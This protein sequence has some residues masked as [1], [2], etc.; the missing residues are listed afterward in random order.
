[1]R[2]HVS[3]FHT[4]TMCTV[5]LCTHVPHLIS[6]GYAKTSSRGS[7]AGVDSD[8]GTQAGEYGDDGEKNN[9]QDGG[10]DDNGRDKAGSGDGGKGGGGNESGR[11]GGH[12]GAGG[13][14]DDKKDDTGGGD[15]EG[16]G[17]GD[18][19]NED[20][21]GGGDEEGD[22]PGGED[23]DAKED[24]TVQG[25]DA[26][27]GDTGKRDKTQGQADSQK[28][29]DTGE[30]N[31]TGGEVDDDDID[32]LDT[33]SIGSSDD[34]NSGEKTGGHIPSKTIETGGS[35]GK[36]TEG[37]TPGQPDVPADVDDDESDSS[38]D[39]SSGSDSDGDSSSSSD[40]DSSSEEEAEA[41]TARRRV[42]ANRSSKQLGKGGP[43]S[44]QDAPV[45]DRLAEAA[46]P[47]PPPGDAAVVTL[48]LVNRA[49]TSVLSQTTKVE[50]DQRK[51]L[52]KVKAGAGQL[53]QKA[54]EV[55][56]EDAV[57]LAKERAMI[58]SIVGKICLVAKP[59]GSDIFKVNCVV[60]LCLTV[61]YR[62]VLLLSTDN[63]SPVVDM[64]LTQ[65]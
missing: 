23:D 32:I 56:E 30:E 62:V 18:D 65:H 27:G 1:M 31:E 61:N 60:P 26:K 33:D 2:T 47:V 36:S 54:A 49:L 64:N 17:G 11:E 44:I 51:S 25:D 52:Q 55:Q 34:K 14:G 38:T 20:D 57:K 22:E 46:S 4:Y 63:P 21:T 9:D 3:K 40:S 39:S 35:G 58:R 10:G 50:Q 24:D 28:K 8:G 41:P 15:K 37:Q 53:G 7:G 48:D 5:S 13:D 16:G 42:K 29:G 45:A 59:D 6:L 43:K 12:Q 19:G